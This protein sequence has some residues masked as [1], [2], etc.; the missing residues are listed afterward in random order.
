MLITTLRTNLSLTENLVEQSLFYT[1]IT[2]TSVTYIIYF[3]PCK[4]RF[5]PS[6]DLTILLVLIPDSHTPKPVSLEES[7][8]PSSLGT[9]F[10]NIGPFPPVRLRRPGW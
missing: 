7:I 8:W 2:Y 9:Y 4:V 10:Q 1:G 5:K 6:T 3:C